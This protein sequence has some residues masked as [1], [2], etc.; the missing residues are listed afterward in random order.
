MSDLWCVPCV[1]M[2]HNVL[3]KSTKYSVF[4][5]T[6]EMTYIPLDKQR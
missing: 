5:P 1:G 6:K 2:L 4:D 3:S